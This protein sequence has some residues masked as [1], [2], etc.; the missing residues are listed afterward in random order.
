VNGVATKFL[1]L[2]TSSGRRK[3]SSRLATLPAVTEAAARAMVA[4]VEIGR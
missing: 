3:M 2:F 1:G 4:L